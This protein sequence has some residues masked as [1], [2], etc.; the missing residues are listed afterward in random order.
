MRPF[1]TS[2]LDIFSKPVLVGRVT[3]TFLTRRIFIF[4]DAEIDEIQTPNR[5]CGVGGFGED[6]LFDLPD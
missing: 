3:A 2:N 5:N 1:S 4:R 6:R